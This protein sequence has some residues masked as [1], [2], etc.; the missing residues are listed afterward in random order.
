MSYLLATP[1]SAIRMIQN[2]FSFTQIMDP[3]RE[4][5]GGWGV[6]ILP[7]RMTIKNNEY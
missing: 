2:L 5:W 3:T 6:L 4:P 1:M 7:A